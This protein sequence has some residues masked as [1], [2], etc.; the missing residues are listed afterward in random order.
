MEN[1]S[2][3][4]IDILVNWC[5]GRFAL[6]HMLYPDEANRIVND[7][8]ITY[9]VLG[10]VPSSRERYMQLR[11]S[12]SDISA[13]HLQGADL[14]RFLSILGSKEF[15]GKDASTG[16]EQPNPFEEV[17]IGTAWG[18]LVFNFYAPT[19]SVTKAL[20]V[21]LL[22][23]TRELV[24]SNDGLIIDRYESIVDEL[25]LEAKDQLI[26]GKKLPVVKP[27]RR[28]PAYEVNV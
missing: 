15:V 14:R 12:E 13:C 7:E 26:T 25:L 1:S 22:L 24:I 4:V 5:G 18:L 2:E 11:I 3:V 16:L 20:N 27:N 28:P 17:H 23:I 8:T 6:C 21:D 9:S 10:G 19:G